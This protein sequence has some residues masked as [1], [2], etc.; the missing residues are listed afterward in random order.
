M[1]GELIEDDGLDT[2]D[3]SKTPRKRGWSTKY[4]E[5]IAMQIVPLVNEGYSLR[6]ISMVPGMLSHRQMMR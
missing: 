1:E 4:N 2:Y 3:T 6:K 5:E